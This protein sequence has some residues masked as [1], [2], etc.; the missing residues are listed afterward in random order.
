MSASDPPESP[1]HG[2]PLPGDREGGQGARGA[3][4]AAVGASRTSADAGADGRTRIRA[5]GLVDLERV[6]EG[7]YDG[8]DVHRLDVET[9][10][11]SVYK[12]AR[13]KEI[14]QRQLSWRIFV[15][16]AIIA[17]AVVVFLGFFAAL[18]YPRLPD[19]VAATGEGSET[20]PIEVWSQARADWTQQFTSLAQTVLFGSLVPL[21][22]TIAGYAIGE[23]RGADES[24]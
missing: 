1:P 16:V 4:S 10:V 3:P 20:D 15:T 12:R 5:P 22:G 9:A 8:A 11:E 17:A 21:L 18:T 24:S 13:V 23:R 7:Q 19:I 14:G 2:A 6:V